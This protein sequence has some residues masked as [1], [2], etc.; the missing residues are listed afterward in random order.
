M[1][2]K[3]SFAHGGEIHK[4][5][6]KEHHGTKSNE[7]ETSRSNHDTME[8]S[9]DIKHIGQMYHHHVKGI[10]QRSCGD[11]HSSN[12][13]YPW[14]YKVPGVQQM[15]DKDIAEA[16]KHLD[17]TMDFPFRGHG[18]PEE[19]LSAIRKS[20]VDEKMPPFMYRLMHRHARLDEND[21]S[22]VLNWID[23]S[24]KLLKS[25]KGDHK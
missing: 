23:E 11:C 15:I 16:K 7:P 8:H 12:T 18:S 4:K 2:A 22:L 1:P 19:D 13:K 24:L 17:F 21:K 25:N 10:F 6:H 3:D 5:M 20:I 9:D 14:Y